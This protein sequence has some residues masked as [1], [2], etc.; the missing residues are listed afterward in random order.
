MSTV[1]TTLNQLPDSRVKV[2]VQVKP[3]ALTEALNRTAA[4]LGKSL[5]VPGFRRG[6]VPAP[7]VIRQYGRE[8]VMQEALSR[9]IGLW[10]SDAARQ[11]KLLTVG[12]PKVDFD[13]LPADGEAVKFSFE[14]GVRPEAKLG[15]VSKLQVGR[16]EAQIDEE[17]L[18]SELKA[19]QARG[20]TL[21]PVERAAANGDTI[22][23]DYVGSLDGTPFDG[24][25]GNDQTVELGSN[26]LIPGFEEGLVGAKAGE[27]KTLDLKF[28]DEYGAEQLAG[29]DAQFEVTVKEVQEK[30]LPELNDE[31][32]EQIAGVDS[33]EEL[34]SEMKQRLEQQEEQNIEQTYR[35]AVLDTLAANAEVEIPED[36]A[37]AR[38]SELLDQTLQQ[39]QHQG[40]SREMYFQIVGKSE[41]EMAAEAAPEA[42]REL[43]RE[44][45]I[46]AYA[47]SLDLT[48]TDGDLLDAL[49]QPAAM[50]GTTPEK[51]LA[52]LEKEGHRDELIFDVSR[53]QAVEKL[54]AET[55]AITVEEAK[56]KKLFWT[57]IPG[58]HDDGGREW[59]H[60][61][62][63]DD[64]DHDH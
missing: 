55:E 20:A 27:T 18:D 19:L 42:E 57:P 48:P 64:H 30:V 34:K 25:T 17:R 23:M 38:A 12:E 41:D 46:S 56:K 43:R 40:I 53:S 28:P 29:K 35:E 31:F 14:I 4:E 59:I 33:L 26:S 49:V 44:A 63:D 6:K 37:K 5:R 61:P 21:N 7:V 58:Q 51:L 15:D 9:N 24:G 32:A 3:E 36:L 39:L 60:P 11:E 47:K 62:H 1:D 50:Q 22:L 54:L 45:A 8:A 16:R 13:S 52:R 10:L 2:D